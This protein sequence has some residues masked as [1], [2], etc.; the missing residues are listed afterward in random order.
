M[1]QRIAIIG[2]GQ[3]G[4]SLGLALVAQGYEV[5]AVDSQ[6]AVLQEGLRIGAAT[7]VSGD[8][9]QAIEG[10]GLVVLATPVGTIPQVLETIAPYLNRGTTVTDV[11]STKAGIVNLANKLLPPGVDF[12]GG[13][14][15]A[16]TERAGIGRANARIFRDATYVLTPGEASTSRSVAGVSALIQSIGARPL[17]MDAVRH[18]QAVGVTSHLPHLLAVALA[19]TAGELED[20]QPGSLALAAGS[21]RDG[22]RVADSN[23][24]MWQDICI[25]NRE[26][27]LES[28][29]KFKLHLQALETAVSNSDSV[30][31]GESF[32]RASI[33]RT[34]AS[35]DKAIGARLIKLRVAVPDE[36]G[37]LGSLAQALGTA[38]INI[39]QVETLPPED[40]GIILGFRDCQTAEHAQQIIR[41]MEIEVGWKV[42]HGTKN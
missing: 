1:P 27:I 2:F 36:P 11:G 41:A 6:D 7:R 35:K 4:G 39:D 3:I 15:M 5:T 10:T 12:I 17:I 14:P 21:F 31:I 22:T 16:G 32:T 25:T 26:M 18:D 23:P 24:Q 37:V 38:N 20:V 29:Q 9:V 42:Q 19:L 34:A 28:L 30:I 40:S 13:H 8:P 33:I